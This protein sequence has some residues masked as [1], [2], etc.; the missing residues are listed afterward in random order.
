MVPL[1][2]STI[3]WCAAAKKGS[4]LAVHFEGFDLSKGKT[5]YGTSR[6]L[7]PLIIL[8]LSRIGFG[9][10]GNTQK[11]MPLGFLFLSFDQLNLDV[12]PVLR[13]DLVR[14]N[15]SDL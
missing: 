2:Y 13:V 14:N 11:I 1:V 6:R 3:E 4:G 5:D 12:L 10:S 8:A 9:L 15:V 7:R